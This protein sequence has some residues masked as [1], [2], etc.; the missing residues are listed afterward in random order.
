MVV[1]TNGHPRSRVI[2]WLVILENMPFPAR[3]LRDGEEVLEELKQHWIALRDEVGYTVVWLLVWIVLVPLLD[4]TGDE[5]IVLI[6]TLGWFAVVG[7]G[8]VEWLGTDLI[9]TTDRVMFRKGVFTKSGYELE[10][11]RLAD[12][13]HQQSTWQRL[14]G[15]GDLLLDIGGHDGKTIVRDVP[16]PLHVVGLVRDA[17]A[18]G[19]SRS[20]G[21]PLQVTETKPARATSSPPA[22]RPTKSRAEQLEILARLNAEGKLTDEEFAAEKVR[23]LESD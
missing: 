23:L 10:L 18:R 7:W 9:V 21:A 11:D 13:S 3:L 1:P 22:A 14:F 5:W 2:V 20:R 6:V 16:D 12:V 15:A 4:F 19:I 17:E 8:V